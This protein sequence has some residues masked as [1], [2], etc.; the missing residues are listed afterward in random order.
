MVR[1]VKTETSARRDAFVPQ[2][3]AKTNIDTA[4]GGVEEGDGPGE[5][6]GGRG[7]VAES[8][9]RLSRG[10]LALEVIT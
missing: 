1:H 7:D 5:G 6:G 9:D 8:R 3:V 4:P 2:D 10:S